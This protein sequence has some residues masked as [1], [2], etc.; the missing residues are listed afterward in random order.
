MENPGH[1]SVEINTS[2]F[3]FHFF[4]SAGAVAFST[5]SLDRLC[6]RHR[7]HWISC[8]DLMGHIEQRNER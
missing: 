5:S 4:V 8:D 6:Q 1:F 2:D 3:I 7:H